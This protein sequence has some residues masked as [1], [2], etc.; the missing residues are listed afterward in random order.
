MH[1]SLIPGVLIF[2]ASLLQPVQAQ[3]LPDVRTFKV[4]DH[5]YVFLGPVQHANPRNQGF[6]PSHGQAGHPRGEHASSR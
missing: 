2:L 1:D 3:P 5:V 6:M 4:N